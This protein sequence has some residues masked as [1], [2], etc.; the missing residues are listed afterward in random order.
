MFE[1]NKQNDS[2]K[3]T[4]IKRLY[5]K[6]KSPSEM[7]N[8]FI[9]PHE[10]IYCRNSPLG[11]SILNNLNHSSS[12]FQENQ[13]ANSS[14][15]Q[16][17]NLIGNENQ[18]S[19][20][21][22]SVKHSNSV[23]IGP[24]IKQK[25]VKKS[26]SKKGNSFGRAPPSKLDSKLMMISEN[27]NQDSY[28][29]KYSKQVSP[30]NAI[31]L[32][33]QRGND[34][35]SHKNISNMSNSK[36][37]IMSGGTSQ[38]RSGS[39][40]QKSSNQS[41]ERSANLSQERIKK[42]ENGKDQIVNFIAKYIQKNSEI[43]VDKGYDDAISNLKD[44]LSYLEDKNIINGEQLED[45]AEV[46]N[47]IKDLMKLDLTKFQNLR[48]SEMQMKRKTGSRNVHVSVNRSNSQANQNHRSNSSSSITRKV[49]SVTSKNIYKV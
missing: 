3:I 40:N 49:Q 8:K 7:S 30:Q 31:K 2:K 35:G 13:M 25:V 16:G 21:H 26:K 41:K 33:H 17:L 18:R 11:S 4:K 27:Y 5:G 22:N 46:N 38:K 10:Q 20:H 44:F 37:Y 23:T 32:G 34:S 28:N 1:K 43:E 47:L 9:P 6:S 45:K 36:Y 12:Q 29:S 42:R 24:K 14:S 19:R 39:N 48:Q 15:L